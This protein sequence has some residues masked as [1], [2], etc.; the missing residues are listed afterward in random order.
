MSIP[1][2]IILISNGSPITYP[3]N[4]LTDF[5]NHL[6]NRIEINNNEDNVHV[7][8]EAIGFSLN[9][10]NVLL[11]RNNLPSIIATDFGNQLEYECVGNYTDD[12]NTLGHM[13]N[14]INKYQFGG[15][16]SESLGGTLTEYLFLDDKLY[17]EYNLLDTLK[18]LNKYTMAK[19][20]Y[21]DKKISISRKTTKDLWILVHPTFLKSFDIPVKNLQRSDAWLVRM[22]KLAGPIWENFKDIFERDIIYK[23]ELYHG[24]YLNKNTPSL[25]GEE[26]DF[27]KVY[28]PEIIKVCSSVISAQVLNSTFSKDLLCFCPDFDKLKKKYYFKEFEQPPKVKLENNNLTDFDISLRDE[29]N[30]KLQL[31]PGI[32]TVLTLKFNK[33]LKNNKSFNVRL[34]SAKNLNYPDNTQTVFKVKLPNILQF[35]P[36]HNWK[37]ALTSISYPNQFNTFPSNNSKRYCHFEPAPNSTSES[38]EVLFHDGVY[39]EEQLYEEFNKFIE[40][41]S[42]KLKPDLKKFTLTKQ[43]TYSISSALLNILGLKERNNYDP[44][45]SNTFNFS[46]S[47]SR[48]GNQPKNFSFD[49]LTNLDYYQPD[50]ILSYCSIVQQTIVGGEYNNILR[51]VPIAKDNNDKYIIQEFKNKNFLPLLNSE[52]SEIVVNLRDH[53][54]TLLSFVNE[55]D[56]IL[57][58][59]FSNV[60]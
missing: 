35:N 27:E 45:T 56:V 31:L 51:M 7:S 23:G 8:L 53:S 3:K 13:K 26:V 49:K 58:L 36:K 41:P 16:Y 50:Y 18:R 59:E 55:D 19:F 29:N 11:P 40:H 20:E 34:T 4:T 44:T 24:Y 15:H 43:G 5:T 10:R 33:M 39:T 9:F 52:I 60:E 42:E 2:Q 54:G 1:E 47:G 17:N 37:V 14:C 25:M 48:F 28:T 46:I 38:K 22:N 6:P 21:K 12:V 57:N 30:E 32:S